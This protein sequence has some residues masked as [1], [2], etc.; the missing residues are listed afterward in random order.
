[1][2]SESQSSSPDG[3]GTS[4]QGTDAGQS[5][6]LLESLKTLAGTLLG[7]GRTRLELLSIEFEEERVRLGS[8]LIWTLVALF[9]AALFVVLIT[10][11]VV[12]VFWDSN[13]LLALGVLALLFLVGALLSARIVLDK[14]RQKPRLFATSLA[15]L[16]RDR[17]QLA[18]DHEQETA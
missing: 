15:E 14:S 13:R 6:G 5:K 16:S 9:C 10:L 12:V 11:L 17:E 3:G 7:M 2:T 18:S 8:M 4:S 1:M